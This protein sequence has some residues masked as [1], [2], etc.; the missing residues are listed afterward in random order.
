MANYRY[1]TVPTV[2]YVVSSVDTMYKQLR[3]WVDSDNGYL[4][5]H[6]G[7]GMRN[8]IHSLMLHV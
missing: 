2:Q 3:D 1:N 5:K 7:V 4:E 8:P 6:M